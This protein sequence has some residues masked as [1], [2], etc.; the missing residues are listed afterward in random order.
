MPKDHDILAL[1][2]GVQHVGKVGTACTQH[3]AMCPEGLPVHHKDHVTMDALLQEPGEEQAEQVFSRPFPQP[4][5]RVL[6]PTP[7]TPSPAPHLTAAGSH[8]S[9]PASCRR[10]SPA[11]NRAG[12]GGWG[13]SV[14]RRGSAPHQR[15]WLHSG[16]LG[17]AGLASQQAREHVH[18]GRDRVWG[19]ILISPPATF[20]RVGPSPGLRSACQIILGPL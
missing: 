5:R 4:C 9:S 17:A 11:C 6:S 15:C 7:C 1:P 12:P 13:R 19:E 14:P 20:P 2:F 16:L 8:R 18:C 3:T 10:L